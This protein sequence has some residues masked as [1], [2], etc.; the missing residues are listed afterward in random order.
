[1]ETFF[2]VSEESGTQAILHE[3]PAAYLSPGPGV[4]GLSWAKA[5]PTL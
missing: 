4:V 2:Q 1:M 5:D 3:D